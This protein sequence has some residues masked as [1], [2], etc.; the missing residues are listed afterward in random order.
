MI[1]AAV[2]RRQLTDDQRAMISVLWARENKIIPIAGPGRGH[3]ENNKTVAPRSATVLLELEEQ[4]IVN[5][6]PPKSKPKKSKNKTRDAALS[7]FKVKRHKFDKANKVLK[8]NPFRYKPSTMRLQPFYASE[9]MF[10]TPHVRH[11][12]KLTLS[13]E[14][15]LTNLTANLTK[16]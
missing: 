9:L 1:K 12:R 10:D 5:Q 6:E 11:E 4:S 14:K 13:N 16:N 8:E 2:L 15:H 3:I 7:T